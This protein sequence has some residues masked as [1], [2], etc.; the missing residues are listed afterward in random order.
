MGGT[1]HALLPA[2]FVSSS[3]WINWGPIIPLKPKCGLTRISCTQHSTTTACAAFNEE[4][5]M[6]FI[7][8]NK[9]HRKYGG[10]GHPA[11][12]RPTEGLN[13]APE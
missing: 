12:V 10:M 13:R 3:E 8:A 6:K 2:A 1:I 5:R 7:N 4:S 9:L 11:S